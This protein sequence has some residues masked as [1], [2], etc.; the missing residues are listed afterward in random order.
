VLTNPDAFHAMATS[1][2]I[3]D[4][5]GGIQTLHTEYPH[6]QGPAF[7]RLFNDTLNLAAIRGQLILQGKTEEEI[8]AYFA[9]LAN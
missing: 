8:Q 2:N 4:M 7:D 3:Q 6:F 9:T 5:M 1:P